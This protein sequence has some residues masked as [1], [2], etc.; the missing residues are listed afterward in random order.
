MTSS[1]NG[2]IGD[3]TSNVDQVQN[4]ENVGEAYQG[5]M[6]E[7][8]GRLSN[9]MEVRV[10]TLQPNT[11]QN[12]REASRGRV[13]EFF[14]GLWKG[15]TFPFK[16]VEKALDVVAR[17]AL[18]TVA[19]VAIGI[20]A[21]TTAGVAGLVGGIIGGIEG[22]DRGEGGKGFKD[23]FKTGAET[24]LAVFKMP[25]NVIGGILRGVGKGMIGLQRCVSPHPMKRLGVDRPTGILHQTVG[26][27]GR[28]VSDIMNDYRGRINS[29]LTREKMEQ[30]INMG[31]LV[32]D[33]INKLPGDYAGGP[34][35]FEFGGRTE[36]IKPD[37]ETVRAVSWYLMSK[38]ASTQSGDG[39]TLEFG[40]GSMLMNDPGNKLYHFL[41]SSPKATGRISTHFAERSLSTTNFFKRFHGGGI[42][43]AIKKQ[44]LQM[45][46]EDF[47]SQMPSGKGCLL[48]DRLTGVTNGQN[49]PDKPQ[50]F[51]KWESAGV[52]L[53]TKLSGHTDGHNPFLALGNMFRSISRDISHT[54]NFVKSRFDSHAPNAR[55][56][57]REDVHKGRV[58]EMVFEP[59]ENLINRIHQGDE[60]TSRSVLKEAKKHGVYWIIDYLDNMG[61]L[62]K[63]RL[64]NEV[65]EVS[66]GL[67]NYMQNH[68]GPD[69]G[70][71][72]RGAEVHVDLNT[73]Y[74]NPNVEV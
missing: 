15:A 67:F 66:D 71:H 13:G 40:R 53:A 73:D 18:S 1:F 36:W 30:Y 61:D 58:G 45:G 2:R 60:A 44:P 31:E 59:F 32:T 48:F 38:A 22:L 33:A 74:L 57:R 49:D 52:P 43:A 51:L 6:V 56:A 20:P 3:G 54:W 35:Q 17:T 23:G 65:G 26:N 25:F 46:I 11:A 21:A 5:V 72:R 37:T 8:E 9:G 4:Q 68:A 47:D 62:L 34:I 70:I 28:T 10:G 7:L 50:L 19:A 41:R 64:E 24:G 29:P 69:V 14:S 39:S 63:R 42:L 16:V 27:T 55:D 12:V